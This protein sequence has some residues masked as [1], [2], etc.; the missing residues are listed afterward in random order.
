[1]D[2]N[3]FFLRRA[4]A[5]AVRND[6]IQDSRDSWV[7]DRSKQIVEAL[8][9]VDW[10]GDQAV[11]PSALTVKPNGSKTTV[12]V[13]TEFAWWLSE[14]ADLMTG[15]AIRDLLTNPM[16][17]EIKLFRKF[18]DEHA[19]MECGAL[20]DDYFSDDRDDWEAA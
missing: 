19:E 20:S 15:P 3:S 13:F 5:R 12:S 11:Y 16:R 9:G 8:A 6:N 17:V 18:A 7:T 14:N 1:M 10:K 4:E 2:M